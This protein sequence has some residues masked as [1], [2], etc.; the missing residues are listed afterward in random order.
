MHVA[1]QWSGQLS[2]WKIK[3]FLQCIYFRLK[4]VCKNDKNWQVFSPTDKGH[5]G[6]P[7]NFIPFGRGIVGY[8]FRV[9]HSMT[10]P[11]YK[12]RD[13]FAFGSQWQQ[14]VI[15]RSG[16]L[17]HDEAIYR[18][19]EGLLLRQRRITMTLSDSHFSMLAVIL[20]RG[21]LLRYAW[22][23]IQFLDLKVLEFRVRTEF[24]KSSR[25]MH[26]T[27]RPFVTPL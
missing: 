20:A 12:H 19:T 26:N 22:A 15:A 4:N 17:K 5:G 16:A 23:G 21:L 1:C 2:Y 3:Q 25:Y 10:E 9:K 7:S 27:P 8:G 13:C 14:Q 24:D 11:I 6:L 18:H